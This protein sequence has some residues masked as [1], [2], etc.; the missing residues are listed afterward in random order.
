MLHSK[1]ADMNQNWILSIEF[2]VNIVQD[3]PAGVV[4]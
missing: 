1:L 3:F 4:L 2:S